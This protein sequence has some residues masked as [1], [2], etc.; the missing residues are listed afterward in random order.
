MEDV[1]SLSQSFSQLESGESH[2]HS[3]SYVHTYTQQRSLILCFYL[4]SQ[5]GVQFQG[6]QL[7]S[8]HLGAGET[9]HSSLLNQ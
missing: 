9:S 3:L 7:L 4:R 8:V 6:V 2:T 1:K 5:E